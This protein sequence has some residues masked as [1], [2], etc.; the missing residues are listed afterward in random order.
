MVNSALEGTVKAS[1]TLAF[2]DDIME[3][4]GKH[5]KTSCWLGKDIE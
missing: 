1:N 2:R 3:L 4:K 5:S